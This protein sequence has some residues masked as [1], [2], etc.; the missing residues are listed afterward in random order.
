MP[1]ASMLKN[2]VFVVYRFLQQFSH[3]IADE[4]Q[5]L[6]LVPVLGNGDVDLSSISHCIVQGS[7]LMIIVSDDGLT[8]RSGFGSVGKWFRR[9]GY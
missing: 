2:I 8:Q 1:V 5:G 4:I 3:N 7:D 9:E 6:Q